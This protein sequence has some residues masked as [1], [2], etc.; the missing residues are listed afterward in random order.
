MTALALEDMHSLA[1]AL[2]RELGIPGLAVPDPP[3][4]SLDLRDDHRLCLDPTRLVGGQSTRCLLRVLQPHG[5]NQSA[6]GG[7]VTPASA[8]I[9]RRPGHPSVN[10]VNAVASVRPIVSKPRRSSNATSVSA[11]ATAPKTCRLPS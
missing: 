8:S 7:F 4:Q 2:E 9:D 10:A 5:G 11:F 1:D 6:I 3:V